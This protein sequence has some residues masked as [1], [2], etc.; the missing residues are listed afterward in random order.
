LPSAKQSRIGPAQPSALFL[1]VASRFGGRRHLNEPGYKLFWETMA[2]AASMLM[3][4][5]LRPSTTEITAGGTAQSIGIYSSSKELRRM[6]S[7]TR[8]QQAELSKAR[9]P[10]LHSMTRDFTKH[11]NL[12]AHSIATMQKSEVTHNAQDDVIPTRVVFN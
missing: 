4:G 11:P 6:D 3:F 1:A 7:R 12:R 2:V 10:Q 8:F 9:E 5:A